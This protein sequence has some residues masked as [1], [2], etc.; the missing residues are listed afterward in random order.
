MRSEYWVMSAELSAEKSH[1]GLEVASALFKNYQEYPKR[2]QKV[3]AYCINSSKKLIEYITASLLSVTI[4]RV[5]ALNI[6]R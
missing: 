1:S 5:T 6:Y 4:D 3:P 2:D